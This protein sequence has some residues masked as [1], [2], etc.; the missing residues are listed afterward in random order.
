LARSNAD[1][2]RRIRKIIEA[3]SLDVASPAEARAL[4]GLK[5]MA[6]TRMPV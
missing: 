1:Q 4:L 5:G 2:V 3:L 6:N